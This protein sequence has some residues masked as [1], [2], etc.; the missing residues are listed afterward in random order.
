MPAWSVVPS[1]IIARRSTSTPATAILAG[2]GG[3]DEAEELLQVAIASR[4]R[5]PDAHYT[6]G[7]IYL[8]EESI[9][10][11]KA[12]FEQALWEDEDHVLAHFGLAMVY[13]LKDQTAFGVLTTHGDAA[14]H[15]EIFLQRSE[16]VPSMASQRELAIRIVRQFLPHLLER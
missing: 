4:T 7:E 6:L 11:A 10:D 9:E 16:G 12:E 13:T 1:T 2:R 15:W 8:A 3:L 14:H 5:F